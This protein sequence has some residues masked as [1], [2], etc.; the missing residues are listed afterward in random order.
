MVVELVGQW[1]SS[2]IPLN[3]IAHMLRIKWRTASNSLD[4]SF[5]HIPLCAKIVK[6]APILPSFGGD[7]L[8]TGYSDGENLPWKQYG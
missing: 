7:S 6:S 1:G 8:L 2:P 5:F 3:Q 4:M